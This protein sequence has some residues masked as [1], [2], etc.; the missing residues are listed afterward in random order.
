MYTACLVVCPTDCFREGERMLFIEP[1]SCID[2]ESC[3]SA[4]PANAIYH[5]DK[6]PADWLPYRDLNATMAR[7]SPTISK[8]RRLVA[9]T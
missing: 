5:E 8:K 4:C 6:L 9:N 1:N 3:V 7:Q 2:C